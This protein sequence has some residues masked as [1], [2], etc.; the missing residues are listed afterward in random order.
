MVTRARAMYIDLSPNQG[1]SERV[2]HFT[3]E[4][5]SQ[6]LFLSKR[7]QASK[8]SSKQAGRQA[9]KQAS[10]AKPSQAKP[11]EA[12]EHPSTHPYTNPKQTH[13]SP[14]PPHKRTQN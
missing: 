8:Q 7:K 2:L 6:D 10:Q 5:C 4:L 9:S 1:K 13:T 3:R 14:N 11:S 12:S